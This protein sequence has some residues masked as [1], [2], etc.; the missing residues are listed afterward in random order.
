M[1]NE[2]GLPKLM[3]PIPMNRLAWLLP[4]RY[5]LHLLLVLLTVRVVL[6][7]GQMDSEQV[8]IPLVAVVSPFVAAVLTDHS[9]RRTGSWAM[10]QNLGMPRFASLAALVL[11]TSFLFIMIWRA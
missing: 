6:R 7:V 9:F 8:F 1:D 5:S 3:I 10:F 11:V 4:L 2:G